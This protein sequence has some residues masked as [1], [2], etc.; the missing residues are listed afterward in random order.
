MIKFSFYR[1]YQLDK[2][3]I[4]Q[5]YKGDVFA[6]N[7]VS[8]KIESQNEKRFLPAVIPEKTTAT[9]IFIWKKLA[10][11]VKDL[12]CKWNKNINSTKFLYNT[13][14]IEIHPF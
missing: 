10:D 1:T 9:F 8:L 6:K 12:K 2:D 5:D 3:P 7:D 14:I 4:F 11:S 13:G